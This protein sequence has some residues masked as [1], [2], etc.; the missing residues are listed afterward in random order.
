M[1]TEATIKVKPRREKLLRAKGL[2]GLFEL[3]FYR[4]PSLGL[5]AMKIIDYLEGRQRNSDPM[6]VSEWRAWALENG[7]TQRQFYDVVNKLA[8][9]GM[10]RK[11]EGRYRVVSDFSNALRA[12]S[13]LWESRSAL[14]EEKEIK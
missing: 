6:R 8:G 13:D 10:I 12:M 1:K 14:Y 11:E 2:P 3:V 7:T 5:L 4:K 9:L